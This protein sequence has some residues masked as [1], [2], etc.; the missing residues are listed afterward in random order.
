M[1]QGFYR[2]ESVREIGGNIHLLSMHAPDIA[3]S[4]RAGQFLNIKTRD[5][6]LPLLRRPFSVYHREGDTLRIIFNVV[7]LGTRIL[8]SAPSHDP[9]D[10]I[11]PL[12][13]PF[14]VTPTDPTYSEFD[15]AILVAGG[16]GVAPM[17]M[18]TAELKRAGKTIHTFLGARNTSQVVSD[19]MENVS[20]ATDDGSAGAHGTVVDL[21]RITLRKSPITRPKIFSCGPTPM[22]RALAALAEELNIPC[23]LSLESPMACGIG[24]CQG[25]PVEVKDGPRK[26]AL[27]CKDGTVF[28]SRRVVL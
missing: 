4:V 10:V 2:V 21:L 14:G 18:L 5:M 15:S 27:V 11:G 23:E 9:L 19:H 17:P 24:I 16:L 6:F 28:D 13:N 25:C 3:S 1:R 26:Y 20:V 12:G 7:G 8:A 22:L